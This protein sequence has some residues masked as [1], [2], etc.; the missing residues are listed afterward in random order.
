MSGKKI[1]ITITKEG[2]IKIE[3]QGYEGS[4]CLKATKPFEQAFGAVT[5]RELKEEY[6]TEKEKDEEY[7]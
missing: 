2:E 1:I 7:A 5:E 4:G 3:A 6:Y